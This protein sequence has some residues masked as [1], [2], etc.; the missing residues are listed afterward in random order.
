MWPWFE[1]KDNGEFKYF[2]MTDWGKHILVSYR[3]YRY[4]KLARILLYILYC[5]CF[6]FICGCSRNRLLNDDNLFSYP[7]DHNT[8]KRYKIIQNLYNDKQDKNS[9]ISINNQISRT[10]QGASE[11]TNHIMPENDDGFSI[12]N[13]MRHRQPKV[14]RKSITK[15]NIQHIT[16]PENI[17]QQ[18]VLKELKELKEEKEEKE[19]IEIKKKLLEQRRNII[20]HSVSV[21]NIHKKI[22]I[23][24]DNQPNIKN[25][26]I[27]LS[28]NIN[29]ISGN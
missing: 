15:P 16:Y 29:D 20:Q 26:I 24:Q 19:L 25:E 28:N 11:Y 1:E 13:F 3:K 7:E 18:K 8:Y 9:A 10:N 17:Y 6:C 2:H 4:G 5:K 22:N 23:E 14:R 12:M 21:K 27:D